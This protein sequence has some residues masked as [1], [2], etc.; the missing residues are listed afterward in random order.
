[1]FTLLFNLF[2]F[3]I[4]TNSPSDFRIRKMGDIISPALWLFLTM[5]PFFNKWTHFF[6]NE[7]VVFPWGKKL[8]LIGIPMTVS[9]TSLSDVRISQ[10]FTKQFM[11]PAWKDQCFCENIFLFLQ[12]P[13]FVVPYSVPY[14]LVV[15]FIL[16]WLRVVLSLRG[17]WTF[18]FLS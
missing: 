10:F 3:I 15:V 14:L 7:L 13:K 18:K 2:R 5:I 12:C 16:L 9:K 8:I 11:G 4:N 17:S 6:V 1:M